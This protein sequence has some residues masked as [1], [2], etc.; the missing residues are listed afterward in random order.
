M[1]ENTA[2]EAFDKSSMK[3]EEQMRDKLHKLNYEL[4]K[5]VKKPIDKGQMYISNY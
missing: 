1:A 4:E 5:T 2:D 3:K